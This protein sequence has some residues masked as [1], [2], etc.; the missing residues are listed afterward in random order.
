M[1]MKLELVIVPVEDIDRA[2]AFYRDR[3]GFV[4]DLDVQPMDGVRVVQLTPP[5]SAC[6]IGMGT[7]LPVYEEIEP[8]SVRGLH[9]VVRDIEEARAELLDHGVDIGDVQDVGG[10]VRYA[11][12]SDPDGNTLTL[13]EMAW[14][15]GDAF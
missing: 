4:E 11:G 1:D 3:L 6:S 7:G 12:F 5:G 9:L 2:K 13:Q 10:G 15:T 8:G 14:R